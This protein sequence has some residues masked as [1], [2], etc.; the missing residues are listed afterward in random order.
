M[1]ASPRSHPSNPRRG[2]RARAGA[3]AL[4][5]ALGAAA[6]AAASARAQ[7]G[8]PDDAA[9]QEVLALD[10]R[11]ARAFVED[12][13][14]LL[15]RITADDYTHVET[16]G[17]ARNKAE[18]LDERRRGELRFR[19]FDIDRNEARILGDV[20]VVTGRYRNQVETAAG[21]QPVK[22]ARHQRV[23]VRRG[24]AWLVVAHQA[25]EIAEAA[26]GQAQP[27]R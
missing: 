9:R 18:F 4:A 15:D 14:G 17:V 12:D 16:S 26:D 5:L 21:L 1:T 10:E 23:Y 19:S 8:T 13:V 22:Q 25:T 6:A 24:G 7:P 3:F 27:S 2:A 20:A 11:R